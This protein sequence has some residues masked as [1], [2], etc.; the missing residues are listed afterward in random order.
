M[1]AERTH[2]V[3][4]EAVG[5][6]SMYSFRFLKLG[7]VYNSVWARTPSEATAAAQKSFPRIPADPSTFVR[8]E[9]AEE[10]VAYLN[11]KARKE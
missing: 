1:S 10:C 4:F 7:D 3:N 11:T 5:V 2:K 9:S 8:H 6:T